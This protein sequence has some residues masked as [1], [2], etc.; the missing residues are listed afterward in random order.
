ML[1]QVQ[2]RN[3]YTSQRTAA[4]H[5]ASSVATYL[6]DLEQQLLR[7]SRGLQ[8]DQPG[9]LLNA[10][11]DQ[12][13]DNLPDL[14]GVQIFDRSGT[15]VAEATSSLL[16]RN[17]TLLAA[18][19]ADLVT[20]AINVGRGGRTDL[21]QS[22]GEQAIFQVVVPIRDTQTGAIIGAL[23]GE[24][25]AAR[26]LQI[27]RRESE[28]SSQVVYLVNADQGLMLSTGGTNWA[29]PQNLE[30]L[31]SS[32]T[33]AAQYANSSAEELLG[34]HAPVEPTAANSWSVV[35]EQPAMDF[36]VEVYRSLFLLTAIV[37]LVIASTLIWA[38]TQAKQIVVPVR[39]LTAGARS[40]AGGQLDARIGV[41]GKDELGELARAFN[42]MA[43]RL[44]ASVHEI[45][46]QNERLRHG[47][48][49]ARDIQMGLLPD[50]PP[51]RSSQIDVAARSIPASEVG[52]DFYNYLALPSGRAALAIGD[53]SG[54]GVGAALLMA[55]TSSSLEAQARTIE[56]PVTLLEALDEELHVRFQA[57]QMNAALQIAIYDSE[58]N[59]LTVANAG[60]ITP[61]LARPR[62]E[63][64]VSCRFIE[65]YGLPIGVGLRGH[66]FDEELQ[67][68]PGDT[69]LFMSDGIVEAHSPSNEMFGFERLEAL[70][71][72]LAEHY[73]A[74]T[75]V[76][77][78]ID[79]VLSFA[80]SNDPHDDMTLIALRTA[81]TVA[82]SEVVLNAPATAP[83]GNPS[84][85]AHGNS[86]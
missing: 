7:A 48:E 5:V 12:I 9:A 61:M 56:H 54:K 78:I 15:V 59:T 60:M 79:A 76:A 84:P 6:F 24:I 63:G 30:R 19:N 36:F 82:D 2:Q 53:I 4:D 26:L 69:V 33:Q 44:E 13:V 57:N 65:A 73:D 21:F 11:A 39:A 51:W 85:T 86:L 31:F 42:D 81:T 28:N 83:A 20:Q 27:L 35:V 22:P 52:G 67:L 41:I 18:A 40:I 62:P 46:D 37:A 72:T 71:A 47:L 74:A 3:A 45:A 68:A 75:M 10:T 43:T 50:E 16:Q 25:S 58:R 80:G 38:L 77:K 55:L 23:N 32:E 34:A 14:R 49:L 1:F 66:Y 64:G 17:D 70:V 29:P 8:P